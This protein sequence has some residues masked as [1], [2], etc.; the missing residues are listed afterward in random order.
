[1]V[2]YVICWEKMAQYP[3]LALTVQSMSH[4]CQ[5]DPHEP[6]SQRAKIVAVS[7]GIFPQQVMLCCLRQQT[8]YLPPQP[9]FSVS[10][11][12]TDFRMIEYIHHPRYFEARGLLKN[13]VSMI[14]I[15]K[16]KMWHQLPAMKPCAAWA[17]GLPGR[18]VA[19]L[20]SPD[21]GHLRAQSPWLAW[22]SLFDTTLERRKHGENGELK[23]VALVAGKSSGDV[24][25]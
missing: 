6:N 19:V 13:S 17:P 2:A 25:G 18:R 11:D 10:W 22:W 1:M 4:P 16:N 15:G 23:F 12:Q 14:Y 8:L 5:D 20:P 21:P 9:F 7:C 24:E 3:V